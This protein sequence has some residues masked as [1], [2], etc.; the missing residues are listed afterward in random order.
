MIHIDITYLPD[1]VLSLN[2][3]SV[4]LFPKICNTSVIM[5]KHQT[6]SKSMT[7][8]LLKYEEKIKKD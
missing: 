2:C 6:N 8:I 7:S 5:R 1:G 3:S 4:V